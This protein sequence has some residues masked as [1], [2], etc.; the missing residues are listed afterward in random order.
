MPGMQVTR[1]D[2]PLEF[3]RIAE[4]VIKADPIWHSVLASVAR[5][6]VET[7]LLYPEHAFYVVERPGQLPFLAHHTPPFPFHLP[8]SD[9]GVA[10]LLAEHVHA[11]GTRPAGANGHQESAEAF[12][13]RW[14][15]L[16]GRPVEI[17]MRVGLYDLPGDPRIPFAVRGH[18]RTAVRDELGLVDAWLSDF[19][20]EAMGREPGPNETLAPALVDGRVFLW[21]DPDPVAMASATASAGGVSRIGHVWTPPARRGRGY[22]SAVTAAAS[23][24]RRQRGLRC[25]LYTDL[26]NPTSN[27]IYR[28]MGYRHLGDT[29]DLAFG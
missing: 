16:T 29:V 7:P 13:R 3:L 6:V 17:A 4:R 15:A 8:A 25:M 20:R 26:A 18:A 12:G 2:D 24:D 5:S 23:R 1:L 22:G 27:G 14:S 9:P 28:A 21:C 11:A 10:E 19:V